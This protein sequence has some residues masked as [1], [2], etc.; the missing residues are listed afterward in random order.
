MSRKKTNRAISSPYRF[1]GIE[2]EDILPLIGI[3]ALV[4]IVLRAINISLPTSFL[5]AFFAYLFW[6]LLN[7]GGSNGRYIAM[8]I[9]AGTPSY[10]LRKTEGYKPLLTHKNSGGG[11]HDLHS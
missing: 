4:F 9:R 1:G 8:L 6:L 11:N 7:S 10:R 5:I 3:L 2:F